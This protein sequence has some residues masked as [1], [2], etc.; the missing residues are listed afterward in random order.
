VKKPKLPTIVFLDFNTL[1]FS[2]YSVTRAQR[3]VDLFLS[4]MLKTLFRKNESE[5]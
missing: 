2:A 3:A 4:I 5:L 1:P